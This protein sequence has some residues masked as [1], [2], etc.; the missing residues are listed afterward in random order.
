MAEREADRARDERLR[1]Q[2][3]GALVSDARREISPEFLRRLR[4]H[5]LSP[6]LF[7]AGELAALAQGGLE[8]E[9]ARNLEAGVAVDSM[10]ATR[11]AFR[12]R[13]ER[14]VREVRRKLITD[15]RPDASIVSGIVKKA[16]DEAA[17][18]TAK[19]IFDRHR[20]PRIEKEKRVIGRVRLFSTRYLR[21]Q[22]ISPMRMPW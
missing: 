14:Y 1:D 11:S 10:E 3:V 8:V 12:Q 5:D 6:G 4:Q 15:R 16:F 2:A 17:L 9:I 18:P 19:L 20:A 13:G 22:Q 7:D 21:L